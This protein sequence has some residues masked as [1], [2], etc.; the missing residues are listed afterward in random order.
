MPTRIICDRC[1][2]P[3]D[4]EAHPGDKVECPLCG[5]VNIVRAV[6]RARPAEEPPAQARPDR[7]TA[8]GYPSATGPEVDVL[9]V[10]P[11]MLRA[12]PA[13]FFS[14]WLG[15]ILGLTG[16]VL[17]FAPMFPV[18]VI[19]LVVSGGCAIML[20]IWKVKSMHDRLRI[21]TRRIVDR[22]GLL[23]KNISEVLHKDIRHVTVKQTFWQRLW[24]VG[25]IEIST[26]ADDDGVEVYM[27]DVPKPDQVQRVIDLYR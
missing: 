15:I 11:A 19:C 27:Q 18:A 4:T 7:A 10:R 6:P 9:R 16:A 26:A 23:S 20:A 22:S 12:K 14:L 2:K 3:F 25:T 21:T 13:T 1:E 17:L 24:G 8:A 5:D